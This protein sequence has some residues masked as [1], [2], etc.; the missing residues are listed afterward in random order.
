MQQTKFQKDNP[1]LSLFMNSYAN[2]SS[3]DNPHKDIFFL[4]NKNYNE[5]V[6]NSL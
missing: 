6:F 4:L 3:Y 1:H 2:A 5:F